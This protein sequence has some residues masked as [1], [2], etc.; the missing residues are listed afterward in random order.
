MKLE[1]KFQQYFFK[2]KKLLA[3]GE[4]NFRI[5][6]AGTAPQ[7][8]TFSDVG[9]DILYQHCNLLLNNGNRIFHN[10]LKFKN[11]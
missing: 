4:E 8:S 7:S 11:C 5:N 9:L 2:L 10:M 3:K 6:Y 1:T